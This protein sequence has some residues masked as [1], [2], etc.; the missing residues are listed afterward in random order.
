MAFRHGFSPRSGRR[1]SRGTH[2][3]ASGM[4][5]AAGQR[6]GLL[7][8]R[9]A[10]GL[11][12]RVGQLQR[13]TARSDELGRNARRSAR[14]ISALIV[15]RS[16]DMEGMALRDVATSGNGAASLGRVSTIDA[17]VGAISSMIFAGDLR[18]GEQLRDNELADRFSVSRNSVRSAL[19]TLTQDGLAVHELNRGVFV[20][21]FTPAN[22]EDMY[23][24]RLA[25]E[26]E[27]VRHIHKL[28]V[29]REQVDA[30]LAA[31]ANLP[32]DTDAGGIVVADLGFHRALV[33]EIGSTRMEQ[34]FDSVYRELRLA[35]A[36]AEFAFDEP[37][38]MEQEHRELADAIWSRSIARAEKAVRAHLEQAILDVQAALA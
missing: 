1:D 10:C 16:H 29:G 12:T 38:A 7:A 17:L 11:H 36:Q 6:E 2:P 18:P 19:Q 31:M 32:P 26:T 4:L 24:L 3:Y 8:G 27:A 9:T 20:R 28:G 37:S 21:S 15:V 35:M 5:K 13:Q 23:K 25:L 22:I 34:A 33:S 30:A 14:L